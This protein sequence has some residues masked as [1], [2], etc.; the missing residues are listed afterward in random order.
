MGL[1]IQ[2]GVEVATLRPPCAPIYSTSMYLCAYIMQY[3]LSIYIYIHIHTHICIYMTIS[4][5]LSIHIY[6]CTCK[7]VLFVHVSSGLWGLDNSNEGSASTATGLPT[8]HPSTPPLQKRVNRHLFMRKPTALRVL[9]Y[10]IR[11][12]KLLFC[13]VWVYR[14]PS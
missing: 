13:R 3:T 8:Q 2:G 7:Y 9:P 1:R 4:I 5:Y 14:Q 10:N 12:H 6:I 11:G